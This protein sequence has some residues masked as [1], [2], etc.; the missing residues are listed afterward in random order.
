MGRDLGGG[1]AAY[2]PY[3]GAAGR[4]PS[5]V[6]RLVCTNSASRADISVRNTTA[7]HG[8]SPAPSAVAKLTATASAVPSPHVSSATTIALVRFGA[9]TLTSRHRTSPASPLC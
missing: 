8:K 4:Y 1:H 7:I 2:R 9:G 3:G 6:S 5:M